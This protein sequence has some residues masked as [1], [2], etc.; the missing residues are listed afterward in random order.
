MTCTLGVLANGATQSFQF[1][2]TAQGSGSL[3]A[4]AAIA[5]AT[6]AADP[7]GTN[8]TTT[9][10]IASA[11]PSSR[12][13]GGGG[14]SLEWMTLLALSVFLRRTAAARRYS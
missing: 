7:N 13:G 14:G 5:G 11:D 8:N 4:T 9:V 3:G 1:T 6:T 12:G 10:T 2:A